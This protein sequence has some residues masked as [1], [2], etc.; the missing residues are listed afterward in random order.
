MA[1]WA[2][3]RATGSVLMV[4][5]PRMPVTGHWPA[6]ASGDQRGR[7]IASANASCTQHCD[8][9]AARGRVGRRAAARL[10]AR[11]SAAR[12]GLRSLATATRSSSGSCMGTKP[13]LSAALAVG[14][15][16][17][18]WFSSVAAAWVSWNRA[19]T[20]L[21]P[22]APHAAKASVSS[23]GAASVLLLVRSERPAFTSGDVCSALQAGLTPASGQCAWSRALLQGPAYLALTKI[24][25]AAGSEIRS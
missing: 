1:R 19:G 4:A 16:R 14:R 5:P 17:G 2:E 23:F 9:A 6:P 25:L 10:I 21:V 24:N 20:R 18:S 13:W 3:R 8:D 7:R 22:A 12:P 11:W 15:P